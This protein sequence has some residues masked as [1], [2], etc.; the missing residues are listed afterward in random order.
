MRGENFRPEW[1]NKRIKKWNAEHGDKPIKPITFLLAPPMESIATAWVPQDNTVLLSNLVS[2]VA[3]L[4]S[5]LGVEDKDN[6]GDERDLDLQQFLT[7]VKEG[8]KELLLLSK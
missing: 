4:K 6:A 2:E 8:D 1:L 7:K 3:D 5:E